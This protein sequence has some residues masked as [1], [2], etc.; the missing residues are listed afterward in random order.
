MC[1]G[2]GAVTVETGERIL[3]HSSHSKHNGYC[4]TLNQW[5]LIIKGLRLEGFALW[6]YP[7]EVATIGAVG[8]IGCMDSGT[9]C[10]GAG[11]RSFGFPGRM[12]PAFG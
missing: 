6:F 12:L 11:M 1:G 3:K 10:K 7:G 4:A 2:G 9:T 5:P 8:S